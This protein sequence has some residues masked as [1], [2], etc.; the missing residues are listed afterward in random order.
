METK[1]WKLTKQEKIDIEMIQEASTLLKQGETV[2]F[3]TET[4]YGLGADATNSEAVSKIFAAK[5]RPQ[6]NP[7]I[8]H[9]ANKQQLERL[10]CGW[11]AYVDKLMEAFAPGPL[12]FVLPSNGVCAEN[13]TAGLSTIGVRIPSHPIA[14]WLLRVCDLPIAAPSA[15]L[16]GK[17]SPTSAEHVW[18]DLQGKIAGVVDGGATGVGL[19]STVIDCTQDIPIILRPGGIT[20]EEIKEITGAVMIDPAL[21]NQSERPKSPGMKYKHYSPEVPLYIVEGSLEAIQRKINQLK[22]EGKLVGLMASTKATN[23]LTAD[24]VIPL[25]DNLTQIASKLYDAL[26]TFKNGKVDIIISESFSEKGIGQA[27]MNR[28]KKA[29]SQYIELN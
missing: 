10:V 27:V 26:R 16:S 24:E 9:V 17:P 7:L 19:E 28:L 14:R 11:P 20:Q 12:T 18:T 25:G 15:N 23:H 3:P 22:M 13:V 8:A 1:Y 6:D 5:G 4:V 21:A 2:A 29:A